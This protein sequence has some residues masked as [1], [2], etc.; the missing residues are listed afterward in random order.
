MERPMLPA[1]NRLKQLLI[2]ILNSWFAH[3]AGSKG[4]ALA[5]YT[6]FSLAP[7]HDAGDKHSQHRFGTASALDR[8]C[9][10]TASAAWGTVAHRSSFPFYETNRS[11]ALG[12][13]PTILA[14]GLLLFSTT[15]LFAELKDSLDELW[16]QARSR[17]ALI[18]FIK[19]RLLSFML[20][21]FLGTLALLSIVA[22]MAVALITTYAGGGLE[23]CS[24]PCCHGHNR[25][26]RVCH[27]QHAVCRG[28]QNSAGCPTLLARRVDRR[29][30]HSSAV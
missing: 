28:V 11:Q 25:A 15:S 4:A 26:N 20:V 22:S 10:P 23:R 27:H 29:F 7:D 6:L 12:L 3:R 1:K 24:N 14:S 13:I 30:L 8:N 18:E 21:I 19:T 5:F 17:T 9:R 2:K 16:D